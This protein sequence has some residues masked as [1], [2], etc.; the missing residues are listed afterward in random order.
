LKLDADCK[1]RP[2]DHGDP[3]EFRDGFTGFSFFAAIGH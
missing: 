3:P 1:S 2:G